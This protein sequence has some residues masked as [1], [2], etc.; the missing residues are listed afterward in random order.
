MF[1]VIVAVAVWP[2]LSVRL[3]GE[4]VVAHPEGRLEVNPSVLDVQPAASLLVTLTVVKPPCPK[5]R[6]DLQ[7]R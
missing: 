2:G 3:D 6:S 1:F 7:A 5:S 4:N